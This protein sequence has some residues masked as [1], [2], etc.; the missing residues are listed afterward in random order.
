MVKSSG[1]SCRGPDQFLHPQQVVH[2]A[3]NYSSGPQCV[4]VHMCAHT[5]VCRHTHIQAQA[6][7]K[8]NL[9]SE[10]G[11][12]LRSIP[13]KD[14]WMPP[15]RVHTYTNI[16]VYTLAQTY[17]CTHMCRHTRVHIC[18]SIHMYT[19]ANIHVYTHAQTHTQNQ[20]IPSCYLGLS[21]PRAVS[22]PLPAFPLELP[23][24]AAA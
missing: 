17:M 6:H 4:P 14:V 18:T 12:V 23:G 15:T 3:C 24:F 7:I 22:S 16:H 19:C 5:H 21:R 13:G 1:C 11:Y 9:K 10:G 8:I 2:G 20:I